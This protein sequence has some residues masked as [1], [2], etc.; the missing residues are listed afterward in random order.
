MTAIRC[1]MLIRQEEGFSTMNDADWTWNV[2]EA[3]VEVDDGLWQ[4]D[5]GFQGR[6]G[7]ISAYLLAGG[8]E[9]V[10]IETG[11]TSTFANLLTLLEQ[12]GL[13]TTDIAR[14]MVT[15]VHLDHAGAAGVLARENPALIVHAHPFG[16]PHLTDPAKLISS[17]TR[18]YGDQME[19]LWGEIAAIPE[20]QVT[21]YYD[22][23]QILMAGRFLDVFFTP[24]HAWHHVAIFDP[25]SGSLFTGDVAGIRMPGMSY[26]CPPTPPP[27]LDPAAWAESVAKLQ[28][29]PAQRLCLTHFGV[30]ND[31]D[32]H[33]SQIVPNL[34]KFV[35]IGEGDLAASMDSEALTKHL[36]EQIRNDID[37]DDPKVLASY[38]LATPSYMAAMGLTRYLTK[39]AERAT[40]AP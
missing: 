27:D 21:P 9:V 31:V 38:E 36:H 15:H 40:E 26:V 2:D 11:P 35:A 32:H 4:L 22:A 3:V 16:R 7:I 8:G 6:K 28:G 5:L 14:V 12:L 20:H 24:G 17:A 25:S 39:R 13:E 18:I 23:S 1:A 30:F 37:S 19:P 29:L 10:L 34:Q 33:L